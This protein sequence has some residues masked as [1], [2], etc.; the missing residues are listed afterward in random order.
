MESP[1]LEALKLL[2]NHDVFGARVKMGILDEKVTNQDYVDAMMSLQRGLDLLFAGQHPQAFEPLRSSLPIL[3]LSSD[4]EARFFVF[5]IA[6]FS[7]GLAKLLAGD[8]NRAY[9]LLNVSAESMERASFFYPGFD[10]LALSMKAASYIALARTFI[11]VGDIVKAESLFGQVNQIHSQ[12]LGKLDENNKD[13]IPLLSEIYATK[14]EK[15]IT[16]LRLD[17]DVLDFDAVERRLQSTNTYFVKLKSLTD[18]LPDSPIRSIIQ[19]DSLLYCVFEVFVRIGRKIIEDRTHIGEKEIIELRAVDR[20]LFEA[21][22]LAYNAGDRGQGYFY[23]INQLSRLQER[24]LALGKVSK[25]DFGQLSGII[26]FF[27]FLVLLVAVQLIVNPKGVEALAYFL[28][29]LILA[30]IV[31][32]GY[33]ALKFKPLLNLFSEAIKTKTDKVEKQLSSPKKV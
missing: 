10:K 30:L 29:E 33:G 1:V 20:K 8:A 16:F 32:F 5:L 4:S 13:D 15:E 12:L 11:N 21:R 31:G 3:N 19:V 7:E 6:N 17:L 22:Q 24:L 14:V 28:G 27:A 26:S 23:T 25:K 9:E 2:K 18:K